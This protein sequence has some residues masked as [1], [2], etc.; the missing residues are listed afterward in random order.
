[1]T[2]TLGRIDVAAV[3]EERAR[4]AGLIREIGHGRSFS[5]DTDLLVQ[6]RADSLRETGEAAPRGAR[7][8]CDPGRRAAVPWR[9]S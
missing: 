7:L 5:L 2:S 6:Q 1:M 3:R 8:K 4:L 9:W